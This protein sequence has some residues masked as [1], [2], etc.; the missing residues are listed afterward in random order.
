MNTNKNSAA[1]PLDFRINKAHASIENPEKITI[2]DLFK[3]LIVN[4][5]KYNDEMLDRYDQIINSLR[6]ISDKL[7]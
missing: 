6:D 4:Q 5:K 7:K 3:E 2:E 1:D